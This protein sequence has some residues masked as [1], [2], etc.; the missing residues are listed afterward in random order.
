[1]F[2]KDFYP[3][4]NHVI[5]IMISSIDIEGKTILEPSAGKGNIIDRLNDFNPKNILACES[6]KDLISILNSKKCTIINDDFLRV[7]KE[8]ISHIDLI[9]MNPPFSNDD[10][11]ILHAWENAP[12]GCQIISLCNW[13]SIHNRWSRNRKE[14]G[15]VVLNYGNKTNIGDC[16]SDSE[17]PTGVE[18]GLVNLFKPK[19]GSNEFEGYFDL[20]EEYQNSNTEGIIGYDEIL[21]IVQTYVGAVKLYDSVLDN[22][23]LMN[24]L[25]KGLYH[26]KLS[27]TCTEDGRQLKREDFKRKLQ[28]ISWE[29]VFSKMNMEKY[30]TS[31]V[32]SDIN[33]F[34]ETQEKVPFTRSNIYKMIAIIVGTRENTMNKVYIDVFDKLTKHYHENRYS[35]EGWK[36]NSNYM[37]NK[38]FILEYVVKENDYRP[39]VVDFRYNGNKSKII[40]LDKALRFLSGDINNNKSLEESIKCFGKWFSW[41]FFECKVFKKGTMH[42]KFKED[43]V[44]ELFNRKVAEIKGYPLPDLI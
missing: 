33:K 36:T 17:R 21:A 4:P 13:E 26:E 30:V 9:I 40:D 12:E 24:N 22:A 11:H 37:V 42:C 14:L 3:T 38:K 35:V 44:W 10:K 1:M 2:N 7:K 41:G 32:M 31:S 39:G 16:F 43:K 6:E 23:V 27:F 25:L 20:N 18:I 5:D 29:K 19:T 34:V 8:D 15:D 28:K